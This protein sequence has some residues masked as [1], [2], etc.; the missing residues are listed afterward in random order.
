MTDLGNT[1]VRNVTLRLEHDVE[2]QWKA[3]GSWIEDDALVAKQRP[4]SPAP[5]SGQVPASFP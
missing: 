1:I 2:S 4:P 3:W 5:I